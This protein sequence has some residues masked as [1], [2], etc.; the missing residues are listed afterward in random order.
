MSYL[1]AQT[2]FS[3]IKIGGGLNDTG[4]PFD[5]LDSES[6]DSQNMD[7]DRFGSIMPR[8][9]YNV[10]NTTAM[11]SVSPTT[12]S[13]LGLYYFKAGSTEKAITVILDTV[14]R[15]DALDGTWDDITQTGPKMTTSGEYPCD[16]TTFN[17][18]VLIA[19]DIDV[20]KQWTG[21]GSISNMTVVAGLTRARFI[22][23][24]QNY[25]LMFNCVVNGV[26]APTRGYWS[27]FRDETSW[28]AADYHEFG[29][30]D[31]QEIMYGKP[32]GDRYVIY[33]TN[34]I[35]FMTF[36]GNADIPFLVFKSNSPVGLAAPF[37]VQEIDNGH[38]FC[39]WDGLYYFDGLNS[40]KLSDKLNNTFRGLNRKRLQYAKSSYQQDKNRY[41]LSV[42]SAT[43]TPNNLLITATYDR[44]SSNPSQLFKMN[45][46]AGMSASCLAIFNVDGTEERLYF[47]DCLGYTYRGDTGLDDYPSN[48]PYAVNSY[49]YTNWKNFNDICDRKGVPH[50]YIYHSKTNGTLTFAYS[51]DFS[52][53]DEYT[54]TFSMTTTQT[55]SDLGVRRDLT[56]RGRVVRFK[57]ANNTSNTHYVIHGIGVQANLQSRT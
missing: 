57:F 16:F 25:C 30:N 32:L 26:D 2:P 1:S 7:Y 11:P 35:Y 56:G 22:D 40:Y 29:F 52:T 3:F 20:P 39:S 47:T 13:A 55:V 19:N 51:Y 45:K 23:N 50:A 27:A 38:I 18:K 42:A 24:W 4:G 53:V 8:Y 36:T 43:S 48:T 41:L 46:Y 5:L 31:G 33:K 21:S 28:N 12:N 34:S 44:F 17:S 37:S 54:H 49:H 15:M 6:P 10:L 9:G 14:Y